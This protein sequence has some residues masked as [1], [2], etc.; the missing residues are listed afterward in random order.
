MGLTLNSNSLTLE[1]SGEAA[2]VAPDIGAWEFISEVVSTNATSIDFSNAFTSTYD[3]YRI[4]ATN[5][6]SDTTNVNYTA[7]YE[8]G[9]SFSAYTYRNY[10]IP[11]STSTFNYTGSSTFTQNQNNTGSDAQRAN[12]VVDIY[13]PLST[14]AKVAQFYGCGYSG[15]SS[16]VVNQIFTTL[17]DPITADQTGIRFSASSGTMT[18]TFRLYGFSKS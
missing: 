12:F 1:S 10:L 2:V 18:G 16:I 4:T 9:G 6:G 7:S 14:N 8:S 5:V 17:L 11:N 3:L 13:N 15:W